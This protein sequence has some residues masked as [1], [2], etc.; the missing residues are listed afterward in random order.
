MDCVRLG[1]G[2]ELGSDGLSRC[3]GQIELTK[4]AL[5]WF[6]LILVRLSGGELGQVVW[7]WVESKLNEEGLCRVRIG[8]DGWVR[9][10]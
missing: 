6:Q 3:D 8:C 2:G 1:W 7:G 5:T 10:S 4:V 9:L